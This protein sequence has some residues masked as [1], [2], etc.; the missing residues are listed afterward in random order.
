MAKKNKKIFS[1]YD[2]GRETKVL[3]EEI[4]SQIKII[5][6]QHG[7]VQQNV[8]EVKV[9]LY[10]VNR[11]LDMVEVHI[12][13]IKTDVAVLKTDVAELKVGQEKIN[14]KLDSTFHNHEKRIQNL[15]TKVML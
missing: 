14:N 8:E 12:G 9:E 15:E 13:I 5:A 1:E 4:N 10:G 11:R 6:E 3:L 7:S 2:S